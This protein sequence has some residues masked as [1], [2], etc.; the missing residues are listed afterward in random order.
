MKIRYIIFAL[1]Y[2]ISFNS[3]IAISKKNTPDIIINNSE[4]SKIRILAYGFN[5]TNTTKQI[6]LDKII[7]KIQN[8]LKIINLADF[9]NEL[10]TVRLIPPDLEA[11]SST[12]FN[13]D[14]IPDFSHYY[15]LGIDVMIIADVALNR[16]IVQMRIRLWDIKEEKEVFGKYYSFNV[17]NYAKIASIISDEIYKKITL[18]HKGIFSTK[19]AYIEEGGSP[20]K[21]KKR[22]VISDLDGSNKRYITNFNKDRIYLTPV[23]YK[24]GEEIIF[25]RYGEGDFSINRLNFK[26]KFIEKVGNFKGMTLAPA[27]H[28][29]NK[30][31]VVFSV[32]EEGS[33][34]IYRYNLKTKQYL[35]LTNNKYINTTPSYSPD[36]KYIVFSSDRTGKEEIY[37]M[38]AQNGQNVRKINPRVRGSFSKTSWSPNGNLILYIKI[39]DN[40]FYI[41]TIA[42]NGQH[43]KILKSAYEIEGARWSPNGRYI[44]YSKKTSPYGKGSIPSLYFIDITT[45]QEHKIKTSKYFGASDPYW[46]EI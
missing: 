3:S 31:I 36:G 45:G 14:K 40:K 42:P 21:R 27:I 5:S 19:I 43:D 23:V 33:S 34:N 24:N 10:K 7:N 4:I 13:T 37:I 35:R 11:D 1:I 26:K 28:P 15:N 30:N 17:K 12:I 32:V 20:R 22:I 9:I 8:N 2:L 25:L 16:N 29:V 41:G 39:K 46:F 6:F 38:N 44:I 18:E